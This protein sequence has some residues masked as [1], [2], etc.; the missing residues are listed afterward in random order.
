MRIGLYPGTF[1][2]ITHGHIDII[3]RASKLVDRLVAQAA[4]FAPV[5]HLG[6][7]VEALS[8][9]RATGFRLATSA[10]TEIACKAVVIADGVPGVSEVI[11]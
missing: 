4:P 1:D 10:G 11:G 7:R 9:D 6:Q 3:R 2:P 5:Y 8:G